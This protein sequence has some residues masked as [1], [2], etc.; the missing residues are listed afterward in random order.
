MF[1]FPMGG[2]T[3]LHLAK[4]Q[5]H[6][7]TMRRLVSLEQMFIQHIMLSVIIV[8]INDNILHFTKEYFII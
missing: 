6:S 5:V 7:D 3:P 1:L 8:I 4:S 2:S